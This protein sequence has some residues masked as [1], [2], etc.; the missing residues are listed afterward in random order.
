[1]AGIAPTPSRAG[2]GDPGRRLRAA[3]AP[4]ALALASAAA[5][6][7]AGCS[8]S[9]RDFRL[10]GGITGAPQVLE[11][12][13]KPNTVLYIVAANNAGGPVAV[14]RIINPALPLRYTMDEND[15]VLPGPAWKGPLTVTVYVNLHGKPG[16]SRPGDM[17]GVHR[18]SARSGD[19]N[20]NVVVDER[21]GSERK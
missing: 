4:L 19:R 3:A 20:V 18:G 14:K 7:A 16:F 17:R 12:A 9:S 8:G 15:L 6:A 2:P 11:Q 21:F 13:A 10:S 1:M 5:C